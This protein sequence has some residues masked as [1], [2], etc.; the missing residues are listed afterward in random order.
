[1]PDLAVHHAAPGDGQGGVQ[2]ILGG[3]ERVGSYVR[4][5]SVF[6]WISPCAF[7]S[8]MRCRYGRAVAGR[9][10]FCFPGVFHSCSVVH[11]PVDQF[12]TGFFGGLLRPT[13]ETGRGLCSALLQ[14]R[15]YVKVSSWLGFAMNRTVKWVS[16]G[17]IFEPIKEN[18]LLL[19]FQFKFEYT[20]EQEQWNGR[21]HRTRRVRVLPYTYSS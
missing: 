21:M 16:F 10:R 6:S 19:G 8:G 3:A 7:A 2:R 12:P 4:C 5:M 17:K 14:S 20:H 18:T 15:L 1:V 11:I 9:N 13:E